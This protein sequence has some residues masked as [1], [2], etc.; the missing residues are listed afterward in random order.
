MKPFYA[1]VALQRYQYVGLDV[2][3]LLSSSDQHEFVLVKV[4]KVQHVESYKK[5]A[6]EERRQMF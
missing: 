1:K 3:L 6:G 2:H 5:P 4:A